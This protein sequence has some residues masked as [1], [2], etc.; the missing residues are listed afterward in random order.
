V[1]EKG[2]YEGFS[3]RYV[4][5]RV[6][7]S[8]HPIEELRRVFDIYDMTM[9]SREDPSNLVPI[10]GQVTKTIQVYLKALRFY[11]GPVNGTY[12]E[13]TKTA[14]HDFVDVNNFENRMNQEGLIWKS[15]LV[16]MRSAA[17]A[18]RRVKPRKKR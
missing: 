9:L 14:L 4:D 18:N 5:L 1:R 12:D 2:G 6:D 7:D 16:Y 17:K 15:I 11:K 8:A 10:T 3:D 13:S